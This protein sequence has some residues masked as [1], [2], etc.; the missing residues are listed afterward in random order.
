M[1]WKIIYEKWTENFL[2]IFWLQ[3]KAVKHLWIGGISS[4]VTKEQLEDE[5]LKFGKLEE[6]RFLRDRNSALI[7]YH[8]TEDAIAAQKNMNG[9]HLGGE[10]LCVDFQRSQ[11]PRK[12]CSYSAGFPIF[13]IAC[14]TVIQY[15]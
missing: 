9:K 7:D 4:S 15:F 3:A 6:H 10:Q 13:Y 14:M 12:V 1:Q 11:P 8:K 2:L 5:F